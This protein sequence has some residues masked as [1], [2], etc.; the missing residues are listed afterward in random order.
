MNYKKE[1]I[2]KRQTNLTAKFPKV[3]KKISVIFFKSLL[4]GFLA[5]IVIGTGIAFGVF[6]SILDHAPD[7]DPSDVE[8]EG[9]STTI[10]NQNGEK[11]LSLADYDSNRIY[12][13]IDKIPKNLQNASMNIMVSIHVE[14]FVLFSLVFK[15][16]FLDLVDF[17]KVLVH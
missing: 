10:Y 16:F 7:I 9:F 5:F 1:N 11:I 6:H 17:L 13:T 3:R 2:K 8:P 15:I 12:V 14:L 4:V